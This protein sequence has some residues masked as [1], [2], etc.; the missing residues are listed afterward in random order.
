MFPN[1]QLNVEKANDDVLGLGVGDELPA[2]EDVALLCVEAM[3]E[4]ACAESLGTICTDT[5]NA[6][7]RP[8][9]GRFMNN[10]LVTI[11]TSAG[12]QCIHCTVRVYHILKEK[13]NPD[14]LVYR[15]H[16][17]RRVELLIVNLPG[18]LTHLDRHST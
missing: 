3:I 17:R 8:I 15:G 13:R 2:L 12:W 14:W 11:A 10:L 9:A 16:H 6:R 7:T 1:R 18:R 4:T 5:T